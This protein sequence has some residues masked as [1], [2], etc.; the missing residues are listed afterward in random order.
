M[1]RLLALL[2]VLALGM[3]VA[4]AQEDEITFV[5]F[6]S[7][8]FGIAGEVPEG[9]QEVSP[10][11][12]ARGAAADD[13][14]LVAAQAAPLAVEAVGPALAQQFG[15]EGLP[16]PLGQIETAEYTFDDYNFELEQQG[17]TVA[18]SMALAQGEGQTVV[19]LLQ[20]SPEEH[21]ALRDSVYLPVIESVAPL[22]A[23]DETGEEVPYMAEEVT[24]SNED[25]TLAGTLT[26]PEGDGPH[27]AVI[28]LSGS[29]A[30]DRD[31]NIMGFRIFRQIADHLT[32]N[33]IAVLRFDD[34]GA[35]SSTGDFASSTAEDFA[36][37]A[38][39]AVDFLLTRDEIDAEQIGLLGHS[40]G[41]IV[42]PM[43]ADMNDNISFVILMAAPAASGV[44]VLLAQQQ[45]VL[46]SEG[47]EPDL[48]EALRTTQPAVLE[49]IASGDD[50]AYEA[51]LN[52]QYDAIPDEY[53]EDLS[54][55]D[56]L[57]SAGEITPGLRF[58]VAYDP[59]EDITALDIPVLAVYGT[60]DVQIDDEQNAPVMEELLV[61]NPDAT[62]VT[63]E[64]ANHLFQA[65]ET[66]A[67]SEYET[68]DPVLMPEFLE[69]ITDWLLERVTLAESSS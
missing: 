18:V 4:V 25:V 65:A 1:K 66:G 16:E 34:R 32:R 62:V 26:L 9:W 43:A 68:L 6:E 28:L 15:L 47:I 64:G 54:R 36:G 60:L 31:E 51:A 21:E 44:D 35:G 61:D 53:K 52:A 33:G 27:P 55:E 46:E 13:F 67:V 56:F 69:T 20:S 45:F 5:P 59:A 42:A 11:A 12:Y 19:V 22:S 63:I 39:A 10:G 40:E 57:A 37:D 14:V 24:F 8:A 2:L 48:A 50:A 58:L 7:E 17:I 29:G 49:A 30:Q 41:G 3:T 23:E 38:S